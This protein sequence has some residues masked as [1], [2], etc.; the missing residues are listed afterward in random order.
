[1]IVKCKLFLFTFFSFLFCEDQLLWDLGVK[2][3]KSETKNLIEEDQ[4]QTTIKNNLF[5]E[6][7]DLSNK[8]NISQNIIDIENKL[9]NKKIKKA[10]QNHTLVFKNEKESERQQ[11]SAYQVGRYKDAINYLDKI[12]N[13]KR[14][15]IEQDKVNYL[16]ANAYYNLGEYEKAEEF[17]I[18]IISK[19]QSS[20]LDDALL[21]KGIILKQKG[22]KEEALLMFSQIISDHPNSEFYSS[23]QIQKRIL[24]KKNNEK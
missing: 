4:I 6:I 18:N 21:L 7:E 16:K 19:E 2:I 15:K 17:L 24:S 9:L 5:N 12:N 23:A 11:A 10:P 14:T 20:L 1:M 3:Q 13:S 22:K 8:L